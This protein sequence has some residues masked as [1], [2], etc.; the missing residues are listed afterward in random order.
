MDLLPFRMPL[1]VDRHGRSHYLIGGASPEDESNNNSDQDGQDEGQGGQQTDWEAEAKKWQG[2]ARKH[3]DRAKS[4]AQASRDLD[5]L[6]QSQMT[7]QEKAVSDAK[8]EARAATLREV[9]GRI[10]GAEFKAA[11]AGRIVNGKPLDVTN[12]VEG[13]NLSHYLTDTGEVD[14]DKVTT[15]LDGIAPKLDTST[16]SGHRFPDLGQGNRGGSAPAKGVD[17]G[18]ELFAAGHKK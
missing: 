14:T 10:V 9:G 7:D 2:L 11:A 1:Y 16:G 6:K 8:A 18:R 12:F 5:A 4:N 17:A 3:E 13:L 15:F